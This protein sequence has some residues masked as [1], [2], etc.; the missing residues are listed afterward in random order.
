ME[1]DAEYGGIQFLN[2]CIIPN[3]TDSFLVS[4]VNEDGLNGVWQF[5]RH[6]FKKEVRQFDSAVLDMKMS[7]LGQYLFVPLNHDKLQRIKL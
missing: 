1:Q 4:T 2:G 7:T 3:Q 6:N 5:N